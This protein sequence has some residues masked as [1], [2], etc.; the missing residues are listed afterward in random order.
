[1]NNR[2]KIIGHTNASAESAGAEYDEDKHCPECGSPWFTG[3]D[4]LGPGSRFC[5]DCGQDWWND[6]DYVFTVVRRELPGD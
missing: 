3:K 1:M 4:V 5:I 6:I 2:T